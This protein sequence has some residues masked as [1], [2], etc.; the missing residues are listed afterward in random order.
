MIAGE[1]RL[2]RVPIRIEAADRNVRRIAGERGLR[3][4]ADELRLERAR[5]ERGRQLADA[6]D[7]AGERRGERVVDVGRDLPA[8]AAEHEPDRPDPGQASARL[9][10]A[11]CDSAGDLEVAAVELDVEGGERRAGGD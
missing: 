11:G 9:A 8:A 10:Q 7:D 1:P 4:Q 3:Q 6:L 2:D 5:A